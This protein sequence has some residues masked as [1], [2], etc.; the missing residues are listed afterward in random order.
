MYAQ[1]RVGFFQAVEFQIALAVKQAQAP[2]P[3]PVAQ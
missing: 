3:A 2:Q 1:Y